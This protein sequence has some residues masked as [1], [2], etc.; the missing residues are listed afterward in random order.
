MTDSQL[1][2]LLRAID[3]HNEKVGEMLDRIR[4]SGR[5]DAEKLYSDLS[6]QCHQIACAEHV[7]GHYFAEDWVN[8]KGAYVRRVAP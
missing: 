1:L 7:G 4:E 2:R 5:P 3:N 8:E 6:S